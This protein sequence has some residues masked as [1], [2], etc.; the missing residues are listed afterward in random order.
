MSLYIGKLSIFLKSATYNSWGVKHQ[1]FNNG[2][3]TDELR[4]VTANQ[5]TNSA[6]IWAKKL[7]QQNPA[8]DSGCNPMINNRMKVN[9]RAMIITN[10][11]GSLYFLI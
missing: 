6:R 7:Q 11:V 10:C 4:G 5:N 2:K 8:D 9:D 3:K 1:V